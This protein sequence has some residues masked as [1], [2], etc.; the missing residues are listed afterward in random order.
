M[1]PDFSMRL[2]VRRICDISHMT[3]LREALDQITLRP[4]NKE[5]VS[6]ARLLHGIKPIMTR[7]MCRDRY[8]S[9]HCTVHKSKR[10]VR[11][12]PAFLTV[13]LCYN[14]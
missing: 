4:E 14:S 11:V 7:H 1:R 6:V 13:I 8:T 3:S 10:K 9:K 2:P 12:V 5:E